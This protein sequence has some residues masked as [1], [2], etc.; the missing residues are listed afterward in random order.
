MPLSRRQLLTRGTL[1]LGASTLGY[2]GAVEPALLKVRQ[3]TIEVDGI[4]DDMR[5]FK[6][7]QLTDFHYRPRFDKSLI[8][9]ALRRTMEWEPDLIALTGDFVD[10][11]S[12]ALKPILEQCTALSAPHG[13]YAVLGNHDIWALSH[14]ALHAAFAQTNIQLLVNQ[15]V[16]TQVGSSQ[17]QV[18]GLD[19]AYTG[20]QDFT[21]KLSPDSFRIILAHEP[22]AFDD[23]ARVYAPQLQLSGHTHGGQCRVPFIK[24]APFTPYYGRKYIDGHYQIGASQLFVSS[25]LGTSGLRVRFACR[26]EI[27]LIT[28]K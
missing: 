7:A 10:Y 6:I 22:D 21:I 26:P 9:R 18:V 24:K 23:I 3:E 2:A 5:G 12:E 4:R 8:K 16:S 17:L 19:S 14:D 20:N 11:H 1:G 27:A 25:G 28:I 13:V 15:A